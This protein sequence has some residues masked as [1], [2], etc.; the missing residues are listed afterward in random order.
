MRWLEPRLLLLILPVAVAC[1][2]TSGRESDACTSAEDCAEGR[3]W[4]V[5]RNDVGAEAEGTCDPPLV[6]GD[7]WAIVEDGRISDWIVCG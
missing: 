4:T 1:G 2:D 6:P 3:C 7:C 5:E